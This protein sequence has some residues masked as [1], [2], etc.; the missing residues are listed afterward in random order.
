MVFKVGIFL[1]YNYGVNFFC[2][3]F[4]NLFSIAPIV[5]NSWFRHYTLGWK[6]PDVD[7]L[8]NTIFFKIVENKLNKSCVIVIIKIGIDISI[9]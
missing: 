6:F 2:I 8:N 9:G 3:Y 1:D 5:K 7:I 4:D